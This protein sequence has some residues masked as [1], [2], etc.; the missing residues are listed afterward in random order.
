[1]TSKVENQIEKLREFLENCL[2]K[3]I[4]DYSL[5]P[6]TK[7]GDNYGSIIQALTVTVSHNGDPKDDV[8]SFSLV[9]LWNSNRNWWNPFCLQHEPEVLQLVAKSPVTNE[10]LKSIYLPAITCVKEN[11]FYSEFIPAMRQL[12][13]EANVPDSKQI[14]GFIEYVGSR[15]SLVASRGYLYS[16]SKKK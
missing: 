15:R 1:M 4:L 7:P 6:L 13:K 11:A 10:Y 8:R 5:H 3:T 9:K 16:F 2:G 14:N 12:Q